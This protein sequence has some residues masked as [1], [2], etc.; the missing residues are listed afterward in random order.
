MIYEITIGLLIIAIFATNGIS[1]IMGYRQ[2][3]IEFEN[4]KKNF[5]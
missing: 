1:F 2:R 4:A 5:E 3:E